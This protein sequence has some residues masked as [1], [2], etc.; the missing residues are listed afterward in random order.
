M[1]EDNTCVLTN[2]RPAVI[3]LTTNRRP[4]YSEYV[5]TPLADHFLRLVF[6]LAVCVRVHVVC[7]GTGFS[8]CRE[9]GMRGEQRKEN[10]GQ[11]VMKEKY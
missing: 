11:N 10:L 6:V 7:V 1:V 3:S 4:G 9:A 5:S 2:E 8:S